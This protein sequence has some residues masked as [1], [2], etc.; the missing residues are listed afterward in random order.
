LKIA[1]G[2]NRLGTETAFEVL[3]RARAL[4][5]QGKSVIHLEIGEP[6]FTTPSNIIEAGVAA[7]RAGNTHYGPSAGLP[8]LRKEIAKQASAFR[9]IDVSPDNIVVTTGAKPIMYY[10]IMALGEPGDEIIYPNPGFPIYESMINYTGAKAVPSPLR[11][12][13]N[14][15]LDVDELAGLVNDRTTLIIL[16]SPQNPTGGVLERSDI[17]AIAAIVRRHPQV[18]VLADEVYSQMLYDHEH[19]SLA[20]LPGM[21]ERTIILDGF[22]KTYAMTGWRLGYGIFPPE[23]VPHITR[24]VTNSVSC[25]PPFIQLAAIE[26][27][28]GPQDEVYKMMAEFRRRRDVIVNGLNQIPGIRC[29][30]PNGA[31]YAF[32]N[33]EGSGLGCREFADKL[34]Y[35]GGVA[36]LSGTAFGQ[37]GE[38]YI[39]FSYANSVENLRKALDRTAALVQKIKAG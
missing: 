14:F 10:T 33:V 12:S 34:L 21:A 11:E 19:V 2:M 22:S 8:A 6:D 32:P 20:S 3:V 31:F 16:N 30:M 26:A 29:A 1:Q 24:M 18:V 36:A 7:L 38:G 27:L 17:E 15:R 25:A 28:T 13:K 37:Y 5:A 39:R 23:L 9:G 4:E 35:E